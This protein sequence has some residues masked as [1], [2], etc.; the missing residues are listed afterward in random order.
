MPKKVQQFNGD[1]EAAV[2]EYIFRKNFLKFD[3]YGRPSYIWQVNRIDMIN[4]HAI[5]VRIAR[6]TQL[7]TINK[8]IYALQKEF[9]INNEE[10]RPCCAEVSLIKSPQKRKLVA[11]VRTA[12][13][14]GQKFNVRPSEIT[15]RA[16][17]HRML[18][19]ITANSL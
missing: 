8:N 13:H 7:I 6:I 12:A 16:N 18:D 9:W 17:A 1:I 5:S 19:K 3:R 2:E 14:L 15:K 10:F 4:V 11:H